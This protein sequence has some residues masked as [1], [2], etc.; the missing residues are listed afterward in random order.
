MWT[1]AAVNQLACTWLSSGHSGLLCCQAKS[2]VHPLL[3]AATNLRR[4]WAQS[5]GKQL[6]MSSAQGDP[7]EETRWP[8]SRT[9][10]LHYG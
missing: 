7:E 3:L 6:P 5:L 2:L 1:R 9:C 4:A 8:C 10:Q